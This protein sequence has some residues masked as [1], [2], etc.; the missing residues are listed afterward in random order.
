M[1]LALTETKTTNK[2]PHYIASGKTNTNK[3]TQSK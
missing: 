2:T 1:T 3:T